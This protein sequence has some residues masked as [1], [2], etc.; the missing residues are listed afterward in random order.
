MNHEKCRHLLDHKSCHKCEEKLDIL[1]EDVI[2]KVHE[3]GYDVP[4]KM[5]SEV[6]YEEAF[7]DPLFWQFLAKRMDWKGFRRNSSDSTWS[8]YD[9]GKSTD[10]DLFSDHW[11]PEWL[12]RWHKFIDHIAQNKSIESFFKNFKKCQTKKSL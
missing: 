11:I 7:I 10:A 4:S 8:L 9:M 1:L 2:F 5:I 3:I 12:F 6:T